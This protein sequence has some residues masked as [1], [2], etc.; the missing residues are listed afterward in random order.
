MRKEGPCSNS[1][2]AKHE[3]DNHRAASARQRNRSLYLLQ[4][5][6]AT[7]NY[8]RN[9][10]RNLAV[11]FRLFALSGGRLPRLPAAAIRGAAHVVDADAPR[12]QRPCQDR[13]PTPSAA[14]SMASS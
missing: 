12:K 2:K 11:S 3:P 5:A 9:D 7:E 4:S 13:F 8:W 6:L 14:E 10:L 1:I